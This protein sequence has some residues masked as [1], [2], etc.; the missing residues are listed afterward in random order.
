MRGLRMIILACAAVSAMAA[1]WM[2][3][4]ALQS[5]ANVPSGPQQLAATQSPV[6]APDT[7]DVLVAARQ[8]PTGRRMTLEDMRWQP[9]P[10]DATSSQFYIRSED[11]EAIAS[12]EGAAARLVIVEGEPVTSNKIVDLNGTGVMAALLRPGMRAVSMPI[13][14]V[15]GAGG[16]ILP[17]DFV[18]IL[19]TRQIGI[20]QINEETGE[21]EK[22]TTHHQ[23]DTVMQ[24]VR[25][26]AIDQ[27]LNEQSQSSAV[28]SSATVELMPEQVELLT[29]TRQIA[30]QQRGFITLSLRSFAEMLDEYG[31]D[32]E[33]VLPR[34]MLD[35]REV[36][37]AEVAKAA[38]AKKNYEDYV[39]A[40]KQKAEAERIALG[41][42]FDPSN[43]KFVGKGGGSGSAGAADDQSENSTVTLI[44]NGA[45]IVV[46]TTVPN[47]AEEE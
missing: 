27:Q 11:P 21:V 46:H 9:W 12:L 24:T 45:P 44:R 14:E 22:V 32:I 31:E 8:V 3:K 17:G 35:L 40:K 18:D 33:K 16:F 25:V 29:L 5:Q 26:L 28:G 30:Q 7:V 19:L 15:T 1:M 38:N 41:G 34:T 36:V 13:S 6:E 37:Q 4:S 2:M 43:P 23:T 10:A 39:R 42:E 47:P 20:E